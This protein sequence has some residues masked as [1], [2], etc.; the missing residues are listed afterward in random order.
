MLSKSFAGVFTLAYLAVSGIFADEAPK[1]S[2]AVV[3]LGATTLDHITVDD[4]TAGKVV[5]TAHSGYA[6]EKVVDGD[7]VVKAFD[8]KVDAPRSV[9]THLKEGKNYLT[10]C[11]VPALHLAFKKEGD[12]WVE[13]PLAD[14]YEQVLF[15]GREEVVGDL[16]K[17]EDTALFGSEA[18]GSGKKHTF[19]ATGKKISKVTFGDHV[20][21]D[22]SYEVF[23]GLTVYAHGDKKV[24]T[25]WYLYKPDARIKEIFFEKAGDSWVRV[26]VTAAA[27]ILNGINPSFSADYKTQ[28]DGFSVYGV[29]SAVAA[30]FA[31]ALFY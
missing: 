3:T 18:F 11:V 9:T 7:K 27:K 26:D 4:T 10:I 6:V 22:G 29:F 30:V 31:V 25:V 1:V 21:V 14:L 24:A 15:K 5:Y 20:L 17:H 2:G 8:L 23:L 13:M 28:Y 12:A 19:T 16:D